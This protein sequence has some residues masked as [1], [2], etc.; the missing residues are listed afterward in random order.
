MLLKMITRAIRVPVLSIAYA[1]MALTFSGVLQAA[2]PGYQRSFEQFI[3]RE[4]APTVP[5]V[6]V[7]M[8]D[9]GKIS[10]VRTWGRRNI[11][12]KARVTPDTVFRLASVSKN[13][14]ATAAG[15][16]VEKGLLKWDT[17]VQTTLDDVRFKR[18]DYG[19][20]LTLRHLLS[21]STGLIPQAYTNLIEDNVPYRKV[22]K[23]LREVDFVCPPGRCYGYQNVVFSLAG[24][25]VEAASGKDYNTFV[26]QRLLTP[27]KMNTASL[28]YKA[29]KAEKNRATP[30][31]KIRKRWRPARVLPTYYRISPAAG[32]NASI[33][34]MGQWLLAQL[35]QRP[36]VLSGRLLDS[37][38]AP[39]IRNTRR[40]SHFRSHK[41]LGATWYGLGWRVFNFGP[42]QNFVYHG[43]WVKG[44]RAMM[45][46]NRE[47]QMGMVFLTNAET[48]LARKVVFRFLDLYL[49]RKA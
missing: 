1:L 39:V 29:F 28:G 24:D 5:G 34:D 6:A 15:L 33:N 10:R 7:V 27:L 22:V 2:V 26:Q 12:R 4:I 40:Q 31:I 3:G 47:L 38:Q 21:H 32:V 44:S 25:M 18:D 14:A 9:K 17:L 30:H 35:G 48:K 16:L 37:L 49:K 8:V 46:F 23:R 19:R 43:G 36:S 13:F 20:Q 41:L 45:V 42:Y 11:D